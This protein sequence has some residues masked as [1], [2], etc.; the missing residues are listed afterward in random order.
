LK[1]NFN[2]NDFKL[3]EEE[4]DKLRKLDRNIRT[5]DPTQHDYIGLANYPLFN[6]EQLNKNMNFIYLNFYVVC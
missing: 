1:E 5:V 2:F 3:T 4:V 6:W